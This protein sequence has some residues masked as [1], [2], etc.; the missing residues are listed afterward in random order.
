MPEMNGFDAIF[1]L[2]KRKKWKDIPVVFLTGWCDDGLRA[3]AINNGAFDIIGKPFESE[4]LLACVN[5]FFGK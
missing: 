4:E 2:K 3:D 5:M 1:E